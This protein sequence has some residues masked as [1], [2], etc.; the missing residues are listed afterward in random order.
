VPEFSATC[1]LFAERIS[2]A[3]HNANN[4]SI[5]FGLI[6]TSWPGTRIE[7]WSTPSALEKCGTPA[8][9]EYKDLRVN[10]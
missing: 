6:E 3:V 9:N 10:L 4:A 8:N 7:A 2:D 5:P 1:L